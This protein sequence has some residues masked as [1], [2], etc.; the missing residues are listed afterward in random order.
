MNEANGTP[1]ERPRLVFEFDPQTG[2]C[3]WHTAGPP[4]P[5]PMLCNALGLARL[6]YESVQLQSLQARQQRPGIV[7]PEGPLPPFP[8]R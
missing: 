5:L 1:A 8:G 4:F 2:A 7:L 6:Y 3:G